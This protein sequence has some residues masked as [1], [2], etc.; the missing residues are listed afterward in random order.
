MSTSP[1]TTIDRSERPANWPKW[2]VD[3]VARDWTEDAG[4]ENGCYL[5][6]CCSC[7][8]SF[9]GHKRR[10]TCKLC[11][12]ADE[13]EAKRR[14]QWLHDHSAPKDWVILTMDEVRQMHAVVGQLSCELADER[15]VR[16]DLHGALVHAKLHPG[17]GRDFF[18]INDALEASHQLDVDREKRETAKRAPRV[19]MVDGRAP[20]D[21]REPW[22]P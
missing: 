20:A 2:F 13:T 14:G 17:I 19:A 4:H 6:T 9:V 22:T 15:R 5:C 8:H 10:V 1:D 7:G 21:A 16:R 3:P 11:A 18:R 12:T